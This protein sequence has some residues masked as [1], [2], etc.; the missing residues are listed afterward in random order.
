M[1]CNFGNSDVIVEDFVVCY[2]VDALFMNVRQS[3]VSSKVGIA[4][5]FVSLWNEVIPSNFN[6]LVLFLSFLSLYMDLSRVYIR[7]STT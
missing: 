2:H 7:M 4:Y 1:K 6:N 5:W 3:I